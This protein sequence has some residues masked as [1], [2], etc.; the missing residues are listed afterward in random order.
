M[1]ECGRFPGG[2]G[3]TL[4]AEMIKVVLNVIGVCD[5]IIVGLMASVAF[6]RRVLV[7]ISMTRNALQR[8][9]GAG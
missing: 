8:H 9:M 3:V 6:N 7:A 5:I 2:S 1:I 4:S